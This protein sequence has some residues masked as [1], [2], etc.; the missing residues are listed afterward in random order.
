MATITPVTSVP[1]AGG[2]PTTVT[3]VFTVGVS[4][5]KRHNTVEVYGTLNAGGPGTAYLLHWKGEA[6]GT[7]PTGAW[8][9]YGPGFTSFE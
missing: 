2:N 3:N 5:Q 9:R 4:G 6:N 8:Y 7:P 1:A